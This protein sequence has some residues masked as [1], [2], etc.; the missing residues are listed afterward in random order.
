M[1][2]CKQCGTEIQHVAGK[3]A[4]VYC[5]DRCR[6]AARR[7]TRDTQPVTEQPVTEPGKTLV[8]IYAAM[9]NADP[10]AG[11]VKHVDSEEITPKALQASNTGL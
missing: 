9:L 7:A 5:G 4:K 3:V 1:D 6:Q 11:Q 8:D 2:Q 10:E